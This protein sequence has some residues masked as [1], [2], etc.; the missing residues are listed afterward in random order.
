MA[1]GDA[2]AAAG[3]VVVGSLERDRGGL[4]ALL[5][6]AGALHVAGSAVDWARVYAGTGAERV[7]LPTYAFQRERYWREAARGGGDSAGGGA[8]GGG[9][10]P[11]GSWSPRVEGARVP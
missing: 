4:G 6:T 1:V 2:S 5:R 3:G 11:R 10:T 7:E 8:G 9:R